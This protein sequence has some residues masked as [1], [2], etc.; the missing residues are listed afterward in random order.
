MQYTGCLLCNIF[1]RCLQC[2]LCRQCIVYQVHAVHYVHVVQCKEALHAVD[3]AQ[4]LLTCS[5]LHASS[6]RSLL[7]PGSALFGNGDMCASNA[8]SVLCAC[9]AVCASSVC[10]AWCDTS[11][12]WTSIACSAL[13]ARNYRQLYLL[14][15]QLTLLITLT[16]HLLWKTRNQIV[17]ENKTTTPRKVIQGIQRSI[18]YRHQLEKRKAVSVH[19]DALQTLIN[20]ANELKQP[21]N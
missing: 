3:Y 18:K 4:Y 12:L 17:H 20:A 5:A 21:R 7:C 8:Y 14:D 9:S 10:S 13:C 15:T 2:T 1:K 19:V 11:S 6:A 16:R